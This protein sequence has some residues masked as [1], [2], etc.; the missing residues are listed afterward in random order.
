M[1]RTDVSQGESRLAASRSTLEAAEGEVEIA[2]QAYRVAVGTLPQNLEPAPPLPQLAGLARGGDADRDRA[3]PGDRRR[4][5]RRARRGLRLRP[6]AG[7]QG[8][9]GLGQR[10]GRRRSATTSRR[11]A[12]TI[13]SPP[14]ASAWGGDTFAS[15][16][17]RG[18]AAALHRRAQRQ[19]R[20]AGAGAARPAPLRAAGRG[21]HGHRGGGQRLDP[22]RRGAGLDRRPPRAGRGG[23]H[24][25]RGRRRGG[26]ARGALDARRARRRPGAAA[27]RG[28]GGPGDARRV[29]RRL[30]PAAGD[31]AADRRAPA[32]RRRPPTSPT[33]T[34][35]GCR[36]ARRAATTPPRSTASAR[37]GSATDGRRAGPAGRARVRS[38]RCWPR[39]GRWCRPRPRRG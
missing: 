36:T 19:R 25:R 18:L 35:A 17:H 28:R 21:A 38:P 6:G 23:A 11:T 39:S 10:P 1:T 8:S 7:R 2:R 24:R 16:A 4:P 14:K 37:A 12:A 26:A 31:G 3:Q 29:C 22:A 34:T 5:V 30:R 27:G 32:A 33:S 9:D 13:L 15:V 20:A